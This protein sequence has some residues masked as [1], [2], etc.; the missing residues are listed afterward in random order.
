[1]RLLGNGSAA[2]PRRS[3]KPH[4]IEAIEIRSARAELFAR[5][6]CKSRSKTVL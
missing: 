6:N 4:T 3:G 5:D 2:S 1:V